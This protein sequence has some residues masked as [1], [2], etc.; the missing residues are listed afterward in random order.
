MVHTVDGTQSMVHSRWYHRRWYIESMVHSRW[1]TVDGT[2]LIVHTFDG[3][4]VDGTHSRWYTV[5]GTQSMVHS[6]WYTQLMVHTVD[7]THSMAHSRWYT[8]DGLKLMVPQS[9]VHRVDGTQS[10]VHS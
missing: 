8:V 2:Q 7:G 4:T 6:R 3:T 5:D 1:F 9:L 10:M